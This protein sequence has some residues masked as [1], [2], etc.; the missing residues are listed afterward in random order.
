MTGEA[1]SWPPSGPDQVC[2]EC[3]NLPRS[4][5]LLMPCDGC[6]EV[7]LC[8]YCRPLCTDCLEKKEGAD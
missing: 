7:M 5:Q 4:E 1:R 8:W 3:G 2:V 6:R